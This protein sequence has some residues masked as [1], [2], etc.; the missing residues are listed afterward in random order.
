M[1]DFLKGIVY[2]GIFI[3]PF[4]PLIVVNDM[5]FPFITGKNFTFRI[6]VEVIFGAWVLLAL[7]DTAYRPR[8]SWLFAGTSA[9]IVV[10]FFANFF[11]EYPLKSFWSNFERMDGYVTLVHFYL[12]FVVLGS[13]FRDKKIWT[14]LMWTSVA[15]AT[16]VAF[17]GLGQLINKAGASRVDSTLGNAAYMAIYMFFHAFFSVWLFVQ[18][19]QLLVRILTALLFAFFTYLLL[20]TGTRGTFL[21]LVAGLGL[22]VLYAIIFSRSYPGVRKV[23]IVALTIL[24]I[25][26]ASLFTFKDS[27]F[28]KGNS[29]LNRIAS[30]S[31]QEDLSVRF[32]IW[33]MALEG[34]KER[35]VLGWGQGNFNYV[36]NEQYNPDLY[37]AESWYDRV[38]N[39]A[40]DWL[41]AGGI[42]GFLSYISIFFAL[43]YY[44]LWRPFFSHDDKDGD[45]HFS[46]PERSVL[47]GLVAGYF[48]HNLVVFDNIVSYIFFAVVLGLI[49][50]RV[51]ED[52][53][54]VQNFT[55]DPRIVIN[56]AAPVMLFCMGTLGYFVNIPAMQASGDLIAALTSNN[57]PDRLSAIETALSRD[58]FAYQ[59]IVEQTVQQAMQIS[60]NPNIPADQKKAFVT[61]AENELLA[62][63]ENKPGDAR[64]HVFISGFYRNVGSLEESKKHIDIARSL[65]PSKQAIILEQ[66]IIAFQVQD[67][68]TMSS[69]FKE[70]FELQEDN[71]LARIFYASS[72][73]YIDKA[74]E[75]LEVIKDEHFNAF[76]QN[77][78]AFQSVD[79][80][81]QR[82]LLMRMFQVRITKDPENAQHRASLASL[83]YQ[84]GDTDAAVEVLKKGIEDIPTFAAA[85]NCY[86]SNIEAGK[87]PNEGCAQ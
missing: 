76:S 61:R 35:P 66:G 26:T 18:S 45:G 5:F 65:S 20:L 73:L 64:V 2:V 49:H 22:S 12:L 32:D 37:F 28:V 74:E 46:V 24:V 48:V 19:K 47:L 67:F 53:P 43:I 44:L 62:L 87:S 11:G 17:D 82:D 27:N 78:F 25:L 55:I 36:F 31:L 1:K 23:A 42:L 10:M 34:F 39:I 83:L 14:Y 30:I 41:I 15:A 77:D 4:I 16:Y 7:L 52:V 54:S 84:S 63:A 60:A 29:S 85:G 58:S 70:A 51:A 40:L 50:S 72:L 69:Y 8:F 38:H 86:I 75:V 79:R 9:F 59:E 13:S 21:G 33:N 56:I 3:I 57:I 6:I 71:T 81:G 68:E 80:F